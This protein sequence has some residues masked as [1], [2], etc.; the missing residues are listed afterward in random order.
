MN[1]CV[2]CR[3]GYEVDNLSRLVSEKLVS[4]EADVDLNKQIRAIN[5]ERKLSRG[6]LQ[7]ACYV[8]GP[9]RPADHLL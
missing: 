6:A 8:Q 2:R 4:L 7:I 1:V 3:R 9:S 5:L